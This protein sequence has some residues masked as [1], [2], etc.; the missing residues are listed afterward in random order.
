MVSVILSKDIV[1]CYLIKNL[2]CLW[3]GLIVCVDMNVVKEIYRDEIVVL[4]EF[5]NLVCIICK[6]C[7]LIDVYGILGMKFK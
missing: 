1:F 3:I 5:L 4:Y 2:V 7:L 6:C